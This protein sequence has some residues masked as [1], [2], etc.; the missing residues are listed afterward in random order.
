MYV[1]PALIA[2]EQ[3]EATRQWRWPTPSHGGSGARLLRQGQPAVPQGLRVFK[4]SS[5]TST[6]R[7]RSPR[8]MVSVPIAVYNYLPGPQTVRL[9]SDRT[10]V[11][12]G[13]RESGSR[14]ISPLRCPRRLLPHRVKGIGRHSSPCT[15]A[16]RSSRMP[17]SGRSRCCPMARSGGTRGT[18]GSTGRC[19]RAS[20]SR[21]RPS[22]APPPSSS[23]STRVC[24]ARR[25]RDSTPCCACRSAASSRRVR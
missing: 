20:P 18:T 25:W 10:M 11:R 4:T 1:N 16:A 6:C 22:M 19:R 7:W 12:A 15:P 8:A 17:S 5:W 23:R 2:D 14:S 21:R 9:T 13:R 3:G 24:S